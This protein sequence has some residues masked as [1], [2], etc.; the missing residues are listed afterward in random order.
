MNIKVEEL[1]S[2][3]VSDVPIGTTMS[4]PDIENLR[5]YKQIPNPTRRSF[6]VRQTIRQLAEQ[7]YL[8]VQDDT[9]IKKEFLPR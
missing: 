9:V 6:L 8:E 1:M 5:F 4:L 3:L 7:G 2:W